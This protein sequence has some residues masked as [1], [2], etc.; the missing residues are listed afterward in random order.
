MHKTSRTY[1][2]ESNENLNNVKVATIVDL[3]KFLKQIKLPISLYTCTP[4]S[5]VP[6]NKNTMVTIKEKNKKK[7]YYLL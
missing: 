3:N 1:S 6:S 5:E 2:I 4:I 7:K